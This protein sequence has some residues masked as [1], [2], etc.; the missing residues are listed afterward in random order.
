MN[1]SRNS[2]ARPLPFPV[3]MRLTFYRVAAYNLWRDASL[4]W[5]FFDAHR[6]PRMIREP[7]SLNAV[8]LNSDP[9]CSFREGLSRRLSIRADVNPRLRSEF[10]SAG[11]PR[12]PPAWNFLAFLPDACLFPSGN[13]GYL[14]SSQLDS[15]RLARPGSSSQNL[16]SNVPSAQ[17]SD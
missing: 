16:V 11:A 5:C 9:P 2:S 12:L 13:R 10:D 4:L 1:G 7:S 14:F 17:R 15:V 8:V 6:D 3:I